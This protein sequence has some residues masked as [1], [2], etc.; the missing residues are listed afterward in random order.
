MITAVVLHLPRLV[1]VG[2]LHRTAQTAAHRMTA[3]A[4]HLLPTAGVGN[5]CHL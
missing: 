1:I 5:G 3:A 2:A 4:V